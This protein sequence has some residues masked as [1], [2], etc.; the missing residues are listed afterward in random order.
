MFDMK[1]LSPNNLEQTIFNAAA[2]TTSI[3]SPLGHVFRRIARTSDDYVLPPADSV[4][5]ENRL[6]ISGWVGD[7]SLLIGNRTL[8][9]THGV[10]VPSIEVD[11]KILRNGYFPVYVASDGRPCALLI[12]GYEN[13]EDITDELHRLCNTGVT[14]LI[15]NCDSNV[16]EEML[17]DYFG[18]H[19]DF[20]KIMQS[21]SVRKYR[22][23]T[24]YSESVSAKAAYDGSACGI[25]S[26]VTAA[27]KVKKLTT[28]MTVLHI[29]CMIAGL[30]AAVALVVAG[31][32]AL[33]T[34]LNILLYLLASAIL[35]CVASL[36]L[37]P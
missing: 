5:Y 31:N 37:R 13:R 21:G 17:C 10:T 12:V 32:S 23:K 30:A 6:G 36:F 27:I 15:E 8:M 1:V 24:E 26:I 25:A 35:V 28:A 11:K 19:P 3:K 4:K 2:V 34:P 16:N 14:L 18:L 29:I 7:H 33:F 22:E 9:E 20:V